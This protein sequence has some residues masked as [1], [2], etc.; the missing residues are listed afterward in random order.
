M[1][2]TIYYFTGTGNSLAVAKDTANLIEAELIAIPS[3]VNKPLIE[4]NSKVLGIV[5][6]VYHQG[7][8]NIVRKFINKLTVLEDK[9]IFAIC[10]YGDSP[11]ISLKYL[12]EM[13]NNKNGQLRAGFAIEMPF[14][15]INPSK[16][17]FNFFSS[18]TL[19]EINEK[20]KN[21]LFNEWKHKSKQIA[22]IINKQKE[23]KIETEAELIEQLGDYL[24][25]R[26]TLQKYIWL[27]V[28]GYNNYKGLTMQEALKYM[29]HGFK[30]EPSCNSCGVCEKI[31]PADNIK[32]SQDK[33]QWLHNCEQC[34]ACLQWCPQKAI[35][36]KEG[37]NKKPR[38]HHLDITLSEMIKTD[39]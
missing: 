7:V 29:D 25:L 31:C 18:F 39:N 37:T 11:G 20:E 36:F 2:K 33:P 5:F 35:Q 16:N 3:K 28:A 8:P 32:I 26:D 30:V 4:N 6:P 14:N 12:K 38:Y 27:K 10:T 15:Y 13:L 17:I 9:Y 24:N 1:D 23:A 19:R 34:F 22:E 21:I